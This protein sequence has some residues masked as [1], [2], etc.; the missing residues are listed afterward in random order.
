MDFRIPMLPVQKEFFNATEDFVAIVSSRS[1]GKSWIAMFSALTDLL[2]GRNVLY[3]AQT[4][5]AFYKGPWLH[6]QT[7]LREF[8]LLDKWSYNSTYKTGTL[9]LGGGIKSKFYYCSYENLS[10]AR[11]ATECSTLYLDEFMLSEPVVLSVTAPCLRGKDNF[12]HPIV[13][14][15]R[16][17]STPN[18]E[19]L[20]QLMIVEHDRYGIRLLRSK[21]TENVFMTDKQRE[22]MANAIFDPK[23]RAQEIEG[24]IIVDGGQTAII[25]V[26]DFTNVIQPF[27]DNGVYAGLD[28]A[29]KGQRDSHVFCAVQGNRL[30]AL[31]EFGKCDHMEVASWIKRFHERYPIHKLNIDLAWSE[32]VYEQL[33]FTVN[34][35]QR[36]F[37]EKPPV[38]DEKVLL[39]YANIRAWGYFR[40]AQ[41]TRDGLVWDVNSEFIDKGVVS[42]LKRE[43]CHT[44]F[45]L[46]R[47]GRIL[48]EDKADIKARLGRSPD[49]ADAAM[50][51]CIDRPGL[52]DPAIVAKEQQRDA[53]EREALEA[54]MSED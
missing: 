6:L 13:P 42:E 26:S 8:N 28:M 52:M 17:V 4:D 41:H 29:H 32:L 34:C 38:E 49:V 50:L 46:D 21:M 22:V 35:Q 27:H 7:F 33:R 51:A 24:A 48:I 39:Q 40:F 36:S 53:K 23:M 5:G 30:L 45:L 31:H 18:M 3:M 37:A 9:D 10:A 11:G 44:H 2:F 15:I 54:I 47:M 19:S 12:G 16:A 25:N 1:C 20:W 14:R 43:T